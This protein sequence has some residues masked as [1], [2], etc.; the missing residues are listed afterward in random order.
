M[1]LRDSVGS[2]IFVACGYLFGCA[3]AVDAELAT[4]EEGLALALQWSPLSVSVET[5]CDEVVALVQS[6]TPN[7]SRYTSR[8]QN[9]RELLQERDVSIVKISREANSM[10][11]GLAQ[12]GREQVKTAVWLRNFPQKIA[13]AMNTDCISIAS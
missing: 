10:S 12:L 13:I 8:A 3:D 9:I 7:M 5:D 11:H 4:M 6:S 1:A 2:S